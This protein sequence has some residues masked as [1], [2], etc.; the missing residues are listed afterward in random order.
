V[1]STD[2]DARG[3]ARASTRV[4]ATSSPPGRPRRRRSK[5]CSSPL[6]PTGQSVGKPRAYRAARSPGVPSG[7]M[8]PAI[9]SAMPA[10]GEVLDVAGPSASTLRSREW[11]VART[12]GRLLRLSRS[13]G[14]SSGNTSHGSHS[15]R[16]SETGRRRSPR[17]LPKTR[18]STTSG[19]A[20]RSPSAPSGSP[21]STDRSVAVPAAWL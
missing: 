6:C 15:T 8:R 10:S 9:E 13:P 19:T 11:S 3:R 18:V 4:P 14:R 2:A 7:S 17:R 12:G 20:M 5:T 21:A 16:S 1:V